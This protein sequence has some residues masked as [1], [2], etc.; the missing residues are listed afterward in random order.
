[1]NAPVA[2]GT[3]TFGNSI[4]FTVTATDL[5]DGAIDCSEVHVAF[6][7]GHDATV[8][9]ETSTTGCSGALA[10]S[11]SDTFLGGDLFGVITAS[12]TDHGV[13]HDDTNR[14]T[15]TAETRIRQKHQEVE[16]VVS[17]SGTTTATNTDGGPTP[18]G[19]PGVHRT[20]LANGDWIQLN[21]PF[22]LMNI[23]SVTFRV[24][25]AAAGRTAG[26]PLAAI[27][28]RQDT[29]D[30]PIVQTNNLVSTGGT[31]VW[32][33]QNF[34]I[35]LPGTHELFLLFRAVP[36][37]ATGANLFNLNWAEFQGAGVGT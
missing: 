10:T 26:S 21:G 3:F 15:T 36:G 13:N 9:P 2:G 24:A 8:V 1:V 16:S 11:A 29:F 31:G 32:T 5:E 6:A 18:P 34:P 12:Y 17:Q 23:N 28:V 19:N 20:S 14:L 7:L 35:S 27:E 30:G 33:S 22:N 37:G 4:P 25:D